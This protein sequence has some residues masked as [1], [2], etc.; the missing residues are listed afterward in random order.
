MIGLA[1]GTTRAQVRETSSAVVVYFDDP[2]GAQD[3]LYVRGDGVTADN[4]TFE[5][6][7]TFAF[8]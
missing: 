4:L 3:A 1:D 6:F 2:T 8:A 5:T 7:D